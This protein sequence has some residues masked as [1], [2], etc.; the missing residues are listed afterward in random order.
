ML[1]SSK[2]FTK[3][4][5]QFILSVLNDERS[6]DVGFEYNPETYDVFIEKA[7]N[8]KILRL[9]K[10]FPLLHGLSI[11]DRRKSPI[12]IYFNK[13]NWDRIPEKSGYLHLRDYRI[14]LILHEFGHALGYGH[15]KCL[16]KNGPAPVM[17]QQT[18]GTGKCFPHPWVK[19]I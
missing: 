19:K 3:E 15:A 1:F 11:T 16:Q 2:G 10:D 13:S 18:L 17:M 5:I 6:W 7:T 4:E 8:E 12:K 14:Y 9:F